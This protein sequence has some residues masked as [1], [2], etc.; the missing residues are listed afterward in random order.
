MRYHLGDGLRTPFVR[1]YKTEHSNTDC[2]GPDIYGG[3]SS[4]AASKPLPP[5]IL[6]NCTNT[7]DCIQGVEE[8]TEES[9]TVTLNVNMH[10]PVDYQQT[11]SHPPGATMATVPIPFQPIHDYT[12]KIND[13]G[14]GNSFWTWPLCT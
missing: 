8:T 5:D 14:I 10:P 7:E 11:P 9:S 3:K 2:E 13:P 4:K 1:K 6:S 12:G